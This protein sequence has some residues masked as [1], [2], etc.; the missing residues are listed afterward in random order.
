MNEIRQR[1]FYSNLY[2]YIFIKCLFTAVDVTWMKYW[3]VER[4][5]ERK[6]E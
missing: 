5:K 2:Q 3:V 4:K 1:T 6:K